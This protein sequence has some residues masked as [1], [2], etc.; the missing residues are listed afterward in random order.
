MKE[1]TDENFEEIILN[2][3]N[4]IVDFWANWCVPC[5]NLSPIIDELGKRFENNVLIGKLEV[6]ANPKMAQQFAIKSIPAVLFFKNGEL[7]EKVVGVKPK[8]FYVEQ[9]EN[10]L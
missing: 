8:E 1:I 9:I 10:L 7:I 6:D 5:K 2:N 4:V 3:K